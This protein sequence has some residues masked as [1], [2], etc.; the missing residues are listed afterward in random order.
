MP[1]D[2]EKINKIPDSLIQFGKDKKRTVKEIREFAKTK[3]GD[4]LIQVSVNREEECF[5]VLVRDTATEIEAKDFEALWPMSKVQIFKPL[6]R[7]KS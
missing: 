2:K 7:K 6:P 4:S 3:F 5:D 1:T